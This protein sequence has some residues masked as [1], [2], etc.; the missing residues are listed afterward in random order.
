MYF[1]PIARAID[2]AMD[3]LPTPGG[4]TNNR[5]GPF[6]CLSSSLPGACTSPSFVLSSFD[7]RSLR[8]ARNSSTRS[9]T[10]CR[11]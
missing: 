11:P 4:P 8:T 10:S 3:V 9:F 1:L 2:L 6:G 5:M 7:S